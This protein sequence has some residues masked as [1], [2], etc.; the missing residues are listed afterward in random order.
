T[1]VRGTDLRRMAWARLGVGLLTTSQLLLGHPQS[2]W[3]SGLAESLYVLFLTLRCGGSPGRLVAW[4]CA[5][6]LGVLGGGV[7]WLPTWEALKQSYRHH[8]TREYLAFG[9]LHPA[10]LLQPLAPY[11]YIARV[12]TP[13]VSFPGVDFV[14]PPATTLD[15]PRSHEF[16]LYSGAIVPVLF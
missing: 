14:M 12:V 3:F 1:A 6:V 16:G 5:K 15:D 4:A 13:P 10:N 2:V 7:Q 8:P 11:L 9:S